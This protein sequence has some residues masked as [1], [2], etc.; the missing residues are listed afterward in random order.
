MDATLRVEQ[1]P[2]AQQP[3]G[4]RSRQVVAAQPQAARQATPPRTQATVRP[5]SGRWPARGAVSQ[6]QALRHRVTA[7]PSSVLVQTGTDTTDVHACPHTST[8]THASAHTPGTLARRYAHT[9]G[10]P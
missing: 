7:P 10:F 9:C 6:C 8:P 4:R 1:A 2:F 3:P 5:R